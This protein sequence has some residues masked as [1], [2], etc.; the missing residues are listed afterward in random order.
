[1]AAFTQL[2]WYD[3]PLYYDIVFSGDDGGEADFLERA[4]ERYGPELGGRR[5]R[6]ILEPACGSGRMVLELA[7]RGH[8]VCG[9]DLNARMLEFARARLRKVGAKARLFEGRLEAFDARGPF[10]LAHCM[11]NTFKYLLDEASV[12]RH[13]RAVAD[14]LAP[15]GLYVIGLHL[16]QYE[17]RRYNHERWNQTRGAVEVT[18][19]IRGWPPTRATRL[20]RVR[21]RLAVVED[22]EIKRSQTEWNFRTYDWNELTATLRRARAFEHVATFDFTYDIARPRTMPDGHLDVV[23][24]LRKRLAKAARTS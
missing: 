5:R 24:V 16:T 19:N 22:G 13:L 4:L 15:G 8:D 2:D 18:C 21:S 11:V 12:Q 17:D 14:V 23:L 6:R 7:R 20:E 1:M 3:T 10:D 9:F